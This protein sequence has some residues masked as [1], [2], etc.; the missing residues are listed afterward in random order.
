[1]WAEVA[2]LEVGDEL[3]NIVTRD[4]FRITFINVLEHG[5]LWANQAERGH[6][7]SLDTDKLGESALDTLGNT[8]GDEKDLTLQVLGGL[9]VNILVALVG[10]LGEEDDSRVLVTEDWLDVVLAEGDQTGD[11]SFLGESDDLFLSGSTAVA[12]W[13][14]V[15]SAGEADTWGGGTELACA[16]TIRGV[17]E[18]ELLG[19]GGVASRVH[20]VVPKVTLHGTEIAEGKLG[21]SGLRLHT[22][23]VN[24]GRDRS[25]L[26]VDPLDDGILRAA[27]SVVHLGAMAIV[28][29]DLN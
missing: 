25:G 16:V 19:D 12:Q 7:T 22:G 29:R 2:G 27:S 5:I 10:L 13:G 4:G 11:R 9:L 23:A 18:L 3:G 17:E 1:M 14:L 6:V 20:V 8:G 28:R 21:L 24:L 15:E 26:L